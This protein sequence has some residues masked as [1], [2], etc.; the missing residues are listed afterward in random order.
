[1][2]K[3]LNLMTF[4]TKASCL[5]VVLMAMIGSVLASY[6]PVLLGKLYS[7]ISNGAIA[8]VQ[9]AVNPLLWFGLIYVSAEAVTVFRRIFLECVIT[10][11][12]AEIRAKSIEKLLKMPVSYYS[13]HLSGEKTAQLNQGVSGLSQLIKISCN[14]IF[15]TVLT[16]VC[17]LVQVM[18]NAT[19]SVVGIMMAYLCITLFISVFQIRSQ[20]GVRESIIK[21]KNFMD[22]QMHQSIANLELIRSMNAQKYEKNRLLPFINNVAATEKNHH[23]TMGSFDFLK[24]TSKIFFQLGIM[25]CSVWLISQHRMEPGAVITVCM[26]FQQL[27]RPIDE[28]YRFMDEIASSL[29]KAEVLIEVMDSKEDVVFSVESSH[30]EDDRNEIVLHDVTIENPERNRPLAHYSDMHIPTDEM[31]AIQG[32]SGCG[33]TSLI[34]SLTRFFPYTS[35]SIRLFGHDIDG[36]SQAE[37]TRKVFYLP[38]SSFFFA[39]TIRENLVYG[40]E[41]PVG[42]AELLS[43]LRKSCLLRALEEKPGC[44][45]D[46]L[47]E[48]TIGE[49][50]SGLSGGECQRLSIARAFLRKP[51]LFIFDEST[52]NLD[53]V[54]TEKVLA[55]MEEHA[56]SVGAGIIHISHDPQVVDSCTQVIQLENKLR[57]PQETLAA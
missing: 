41:H 54:T 32:P 17:T 6:W 34:R 27:V 46:N 43:A 30:S 26:L 36:F 45:L 3:Y 8:T 10:D 14:D 51:K 35:G 24:Q 39:G 55:A 42:D 2:K 22:G 29:V 47:L 11:H 57:T 13:S 15:A 4:K 23:Y 56:R 48:Y 31:V 18:S 21:Q 28:V 40:L 25:A 53:G 50:G 52:A 20:N 37:L 7:A 44:N 12:E 16:A 33:K 9:Q 38:Q 5:A 1:M 49:N 19:L